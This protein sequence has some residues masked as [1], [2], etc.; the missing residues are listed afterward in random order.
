MA[1]SA[2]SARFRIN[3][4]DGSPRKRRVRRIVLVLVVI[5]AGAPLAWR[6]EDAFPGA[7]DSIMAVAWLA[8][9]GVARRASRGLTPLVLFSLTMA[10]IYVA[11]AIVDARGG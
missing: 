7:L 10:A 11:L 8:C 6:L 1:D 3:L 4:N 2:E 5:I 9:A